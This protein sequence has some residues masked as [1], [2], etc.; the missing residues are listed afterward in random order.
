MVRFLN[1]ETVE[2]GSL[3]LGDHSIN[4]ELPSERPLDPKDIRGIQ[5]QTPP[6]E[7]PHSVQRLAALL[8]AYP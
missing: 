7:Q 6:V 5:F 3:H 4:H 1:L 8:A 2:I